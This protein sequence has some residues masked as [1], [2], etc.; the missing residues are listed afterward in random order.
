MEAGGRI[1]IERDVLTCP[2]QRK[3]DID[4]LKV[5]CGNDDVANPAAGI[6]GPPMNVVASELGRP[7]PGKEDHG[8]GSTS[9]I[10]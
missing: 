8:V 3:A 6:C 1:D 10:D 5:S 7:R 2:V 9:N 4:L